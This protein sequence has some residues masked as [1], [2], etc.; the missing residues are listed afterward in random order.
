MSDE[1]ES[2]C[3]HVVCWGQRVRHCLGMCVC[4]HVVCWRLAKG[5]ALCG[6]V[7]GHAWLCVYVWLWVCGCR[8]AC[9]WSTG[10]PEWV[11]Q[12]RH[13]CVAVW[14]CVHACGYVY[15]VYGVCVC[16]G[17]GWGGRCL[18]E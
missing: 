14:L 4:M 12:C 13:V 11:R 2:V 5:E 18:G 10:G 7:W 8:C 1:A 16:K 9:M 15:G 3:L 6:H 17:R